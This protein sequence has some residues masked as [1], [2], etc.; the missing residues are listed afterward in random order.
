MPA[1]ACSTCIWFQPTDAPAGICRFNPPIVGANRF[2]QWAIVEQDDWCNQWT[3]TDPYPP[4]LPTISRIVADPPGTGSTTAVLMGIGSTFT[5]TPV[6]TG[7][8]AAI[9]GGTCANSGANGGLN[10]TGY[11]GSG[12]PPANGA[13]APAGTVWSITQHYFMTGA[14]DVSG[15]TVIGGATGLP[16]NVAH[17]FDIAVA[18]TGGGTATVTDLQCLLWE[19]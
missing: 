13:A 15:F 10:I 16:L 5:I 14:R 17:W 4:Q 7:R 3:S 2:S 9:V 1:R 11:Q 12:T 18:A 8:I 19:L 6:L